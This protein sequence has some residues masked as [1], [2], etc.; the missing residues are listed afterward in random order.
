MNVSLFNIFV[1]EFLK[2]DA[3][4]VM[5]IELLIKRGQIIDLTIEVIEGK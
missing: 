3:K 1:K 4:A 5:H 2:S